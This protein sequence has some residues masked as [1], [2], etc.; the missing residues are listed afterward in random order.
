[1]GR[2]PRRS[3]G[4][5]PAGH[6]ALGF[7]QISVHR[8][9]FPSQMTA[10]VVTQLYLAFRSGDFYTQQQLNTSGITALRSSLTDISSDL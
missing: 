8:A 1:M 10:R 4:R 7:R 2:P 5:I 9:G 6:T 3:A